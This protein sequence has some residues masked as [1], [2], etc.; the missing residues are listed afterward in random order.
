MPARSTTGMC[1]AASICFMVTHPFRHG[2]TS[3]LAGIRISSSPRRRPGYPHSSGFCWFALPCNGQGRQG[4]R[5]LPCCDRHLSARSRWQKA[6]L[7]SCVFPTVVLPSN[8][9]RIT[10]PD[11]EET[12]TLP[13]QGGAPAPGCGTRLFPRTRISA[14]RVGGHAAQGNFSV[15]HPSARQGHSVL[16]SRLNAEE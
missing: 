3:V 5:Q 10:S 12:H 7:V 11:Q 15:A 16:G 8:V 2:Q 6:S 1:T 4:P 14:V 9:P 13:T